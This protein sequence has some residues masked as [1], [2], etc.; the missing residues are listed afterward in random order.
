MNFEFI[1][2]IDDLEK[3]SREVVWQNFERLAA[4]I[5]EENDFRVEVN[6]VKTLNKRRRQYDVIA[7]KEGR[8]YLAECK[9][10]SGNR[11][12]LSQLKKAIEKH[13]ERSEFY[14]DLTDE[15]PIPIIVTLIE[16]EIQLYEGIPIIPIS[17]LNSFLNE[18]E[19]G[20]CEPSDMD[21]HLYDED[22]N[23]SHQ[24]RLHEN[25]V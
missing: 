6:V 2:S 5:F 19:R 21:F 22:Q 23:C 18:I 4:F 13:I 8:T 25:D 3:A 11:Y 7:R 24:P 20:A 9:K 14:R 12:R 16:E 17:K 15:A 1:K 10:W